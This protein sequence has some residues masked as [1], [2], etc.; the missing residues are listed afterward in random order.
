MN[1]Q[2]GLFGDDASTG[3]PL[4]VATEHLFHWKAPEGGGR[5]PLGALGSPRKVCESR[6]GK[7]WKTPLEAPGSSP[8]AAGASGRP[9]KAP[10]VSGRLCKALKDLGQPWK[11]L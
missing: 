5:P 8:K 6:F 1:S 10:D 4:P 9:W 7:P 2:T 11:A 3:T